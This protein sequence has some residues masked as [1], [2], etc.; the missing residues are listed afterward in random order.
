MS[1]TIAVAMSIKAVSP[2]FICASP[3]FLFYLL[4]GVFFHEK[5]KRLSARATSN[6]RATFGAFACL[7]SIGSKKRSFLDMVIV[8]FFYTFFYK[9]VYLSGDLL[10]NCKTG[11]IVMKGLFHRILD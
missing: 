2:V 9:N 6:P 10:Q 4:K 11:I 3:V 7:I 5:T 8:V 1:M